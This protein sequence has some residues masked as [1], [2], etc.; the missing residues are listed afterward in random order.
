[1]RFVT[2]EERVRHENRPKRG[3]NEGAYKTN[4]IDIRWNMM[5]VFCNTSTP[6]E[7]GGKEVR[8]TVWWIAA[9]QWPSPAHK[10]STQTGCKLPCCRDKD[11][12]INVSVVD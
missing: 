1:M 5:S 11:T 7:V 2:K 8:N 10:S 9:V 3:E 12:V 4:L 6:K